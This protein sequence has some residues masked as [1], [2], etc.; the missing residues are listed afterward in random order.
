MLLFVV[1]DF[2]VVCCCGIV[3]LCLAMLGLDFDYWIWP[4]LMLWWFCG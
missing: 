3:G 1:G 2:D 4:G